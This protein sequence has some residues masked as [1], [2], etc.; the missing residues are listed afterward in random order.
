MP[1]LESHFAAEITVAEPTV[2]GSLA[3]FALIADGPPSVQYVSFAEASQHGATVKE[4]D[5]GASVN[6]LT[7]H[8]AL[9]ESVLLYEGEEV[10]GAQQNRTLDVSVL[11]AAKSSLR[12]PVSCVEAGR[13]DGRRHDEAFAP[14]PQTANP[15]LRQMKNTQVRASVAAGFD[16]RAAQGEVWREVSETAARHGV[17]SDTSAMHDVFERRRQ[18]LDQVGREIKMNCSQVGMLAAV[19]GRFTVLDFVSDVDAF[20]SLHGPLVQGYSF[21]ALDVPAAPPPSSDD[22]RD[23]IE[24]LLAAPFTA[25][26]AVGLGENVSF[27]FGG[28]AGTG[29]VCEGELVTL[30]AFADEPRSEAPAAG[31]RVRRPSRRRLR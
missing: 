4:L 15:R 21:D 9:D 24:L 30:T 2:V 25:R 12:V 11:V 10:L 13:W 17:N 27:A 28:L 31:R 6:D 7:V 23:F 26:P 20:G 18:Q 5:G 1:T 8:N 3:V 14:A 29:L 22:A 19:G 16:A